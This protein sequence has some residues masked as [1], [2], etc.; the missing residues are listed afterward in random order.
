MFD[1]PFTTK[2]QSSKF[3]AKNTGSTIWLY[4]KKHAVCYCLDHYGFVYKQNNYIRVYYASL[5]A[6]LFNWPKHNAKGTF[7]EKT[8]D[9]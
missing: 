1:L 2:Q 5:L 6:V 3:I 8:I 7:F 4:V 9:E